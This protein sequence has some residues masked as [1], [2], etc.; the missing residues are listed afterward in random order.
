M[1]HTARC[2]TFPTENTTQKVNLK[3]LFETH[4]Q[5]SLIKMKEYVCEKLMEV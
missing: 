5:D 2:T 3:A 1:F 4:F